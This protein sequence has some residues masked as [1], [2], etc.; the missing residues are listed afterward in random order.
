SAWRNDFTLDLRCPRR[1]KCLLRST[2]DLGCR[3]VGLSDGPLRRLDSLEKEIPNAGKDASDQQER[4][5][6]DQEREP[7]GQVKCCYQAERCSDVEQNRRTQCEVSG[8]SEKPG[9]RP[10][11]LRTGK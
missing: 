1:C 5:G 6:Y 3:K 9:P 11:I 4:D 2:L 7:G 10:T 8:D